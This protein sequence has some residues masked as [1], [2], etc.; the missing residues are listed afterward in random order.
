MP[1]DNRFTAFINPLV[2]F[3][4]DEAWADKTA[5][6]SAEMTLSLLCPPGTPNDAKNLVKRY[7]TISTESERLFA[8]PYEPRI[9]EKLVWPLRY[10]KASYVTGNNLAVV[11]LCGIVSEMVAILLWKLAETSLNGRQMTEEDE[12]A[13][14]GRP[15]EKLGQER[16][17]KIL[18]SY[19]IVTSHVVQMF[20]RVRSTRN[21]Y[22]HLWSQDYDRLSEDAVKCFRDA[23]CL[24]VEA[25]GQDVKDGAILLNP[26]LL[27][28]LQRKGV[29]EPLQDSAV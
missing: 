27:K 24:V 28:Y 9:L 5:S 10:A 21:K 20:N 14:F 11:A 17:V 15:F 3:E 6:R 29:Y 8:A 25:I 22:L 16:R 1:N 19:D 4:L 18:D 2:F 23:T 7:K 13:L 26:K 12:A